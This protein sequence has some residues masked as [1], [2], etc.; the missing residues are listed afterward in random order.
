M[1]RASIATVAMGTKGGSW[2]S[3][4]GFPLLWAKGLQLAGAIMRWV[5]LL[6]VFP[7]AGFFLL[8]VEPPAYIVGDDRRS[9][10]LLAVG[11]LIELAKEVFG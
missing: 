5:A 7:R 6:A 11:L 2:F 9:G 10:P 4:Q 3:A 8:R 1:K